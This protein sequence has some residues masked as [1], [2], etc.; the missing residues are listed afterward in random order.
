MKVEKRVKIRLIRG[1]VS[2]HHLAWES[3]IQHFL[4]LPLTGWPQPTLML[5]LF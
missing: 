2:S 1:L 3:E 5:F 4:V